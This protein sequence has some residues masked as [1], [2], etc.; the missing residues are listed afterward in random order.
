MEGRINLRDLELSGLGPERDFSEGAYYNPWGDCLQVWLESTGSRAKRIDSFLTLYLSRDKGR[1]IGLQIKGV[2]N[3][4]KKHILLRKALKEKN[5]VFL[6]LILLVLHYESCQRDLTRQ[7]MKILQTTYNQLFQE[8]ANKEVEIP[9][10]V[11]ELA[12]SA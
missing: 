3:L 2:K 1:I 12:K 5:R 9:E 11:K 8:I 6:A 7:E 4:L 10:E